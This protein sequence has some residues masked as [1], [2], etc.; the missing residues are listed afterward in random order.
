MKFGGKFE[1]LVKNI[2]SET[3]YTDIYP[4]TF[5]EFIK[6]YK[7]QKNDNT[8]YVQFT[9]YA[10]STL[11][12]TPYSDPD[13]KDPVGIYAYPLKYVIEYPADVKYGRSAKYL[14]I[15]KQ[16]DI[17]RSLN[18]SNMENWLAK[19]ILA[20]IFKNQDPETLLTIAQK[21]FKFPNNRTRSAKQFF[22]NIQYDLTQKIDT[23]SNIPY[24]LRSGEEQTKLLL[25]IGITCLIDK[26]GNRK[27]AVINKSE[28]EQTIFLNRKSF[29]VIDIFQLRN[30]VSNNL[31]ENPDG[32]I[33]LAQK[34]ANSILNELN[35]KISEAS[36]S[37]HE[38]VKW[39]GARSYD[40]FSKRGFHLKIT[41][42]AELPEVWSFDEP[43]KHKDS[44]EFSRYYPIIELSSDK[45]YIKQKYHR[46]AKIKDIAD[47]VKRLYDN[48]KPDPLFK[49]ITSKSYK[50]EQ[51]RKKAEQQKETTKR[52][53]EKDKEEEKDF[54]TDL[55][56]SLINKLK[57][58]VNISEDDNTLYHKA[59]EY[60]M[61]KILSMYQVG[62]IIDQQKL[63]H[64]W[65]QKDLLIILDKMNYNIGNLKPIFNGIIL[66]NE[67]QRTPIRF[68]IRNMI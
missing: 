47:D 59:L 50:E 13:H 4:K 35:D 19:S 54:R 2:L 3:H 31:K 21:V 37:K 25:S 18:L 48:A 15:L 53:I 30:N 34:L 28:P 51:E 38:K 12:K 11:E 46:G 60:L 43:T 33:D 68:I 61:R 14:R 49:Q 23:D 55:L 16:K 67:L 39:G 20:K 8:L 10:T 1:E 22:A 26:S 57:L 6:K 44:K 45:E 9:N 42:E 41:Y 63:N 58:N 7:K 17:N 24:R 27:L 36:E 64:F 65:N 62:E 32:N 66:N 40:F 5:L 29:D 56:M 52:L